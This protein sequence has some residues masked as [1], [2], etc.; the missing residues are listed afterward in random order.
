MFIVK[1][2]AFLQVYPHNWGATLISCFQSD[3]QELLNLFFRGYGMKHSS[4]RSALI[5]FAIGGALIFSQAQKS[6]ADDHGRSRCQQ[7]VEKAEDHYRHEAREHGRHS[8]QAEEARAKLN[9]EWDRCWNETHAWYDPHR[10][11][12]R[13][14]RDWDHNY[15]WDHDHDRDDH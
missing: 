11:E 14:D 3:N 1:A 7:K 4:L 6:F 9:N 10:H 8:R 2:P 12:W 13:N 15:D 5:G